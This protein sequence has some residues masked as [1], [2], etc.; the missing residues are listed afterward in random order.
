MLLNK[1]FFCFEQFKKSLSV[2]CHPPCSIP[3][4]AETLRNF[5]FGFWVR[6]SLEKILDHFVVFLR[7]ETADD[8]LSDM[9]ELSSKG[10]KVR[11][12]GCIGFPDFSQT[13][14]DA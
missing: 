7:R 5:L 9:P 14:F 12:L 4:I 2:H 1:K 13:T 8:R 11:K 3:N 6:V 10:L